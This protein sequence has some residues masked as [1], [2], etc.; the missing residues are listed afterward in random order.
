MPK[1]RPRC[2]G[3]KKR[4]ENLRP[5]V[6]SHEPLPILM[7]Q[8]AQ[9]PVDSRHA[10]ESPLQTSAGVPRQGLEILYSGFQWGTGTQEED[11][12]KERQFGAAGGS[13]SLLV[14]DSN[15]WGRGAQKKLHRGE[16]FT[17]QPPAGQWLVKTTPRSR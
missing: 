7:E 13:Q 9:I 10:P 8:G 17:W 11:R 15:L 6:L 16:W 12:A 4:G 5:Q 14:P 1:A 2:G 3:S